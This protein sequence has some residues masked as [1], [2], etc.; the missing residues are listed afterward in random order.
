MVTSNTSNAPTSSAIAVTGTETAARVK[1]PVITPAPGTYAAA[2]SVTI[3]DATAGATIFY[4]T[5]G[6]NP[7]TNSPKYTSPFTVSVSE[8][9]IA[10]GVLSGFTNSALASASY[11]IG[12]STNGVPRRH[13]RI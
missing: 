2:F 11:T 8:Q 5:D 9:I 7:T 3:T 12:A 10:M 4:T 6:T 13:S 1:T